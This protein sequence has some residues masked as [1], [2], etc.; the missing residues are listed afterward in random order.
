LKLEGMVASASGSHI[1]CCSEEGTALAP[2]EVGIR[3]AQKMIEMGA[4]DYIN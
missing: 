3:L 2:E 4:L 1:L